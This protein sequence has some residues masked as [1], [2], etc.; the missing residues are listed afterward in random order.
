MTAG[1]KASYDWFKK[2]IKTYIPKSK[3]DEEYVKMQRRKISSGSV[4]TFNYKQPVGKGKKSLRFFDEHPVDII[5]YIK[6]N[7]MMC[8][9]FHYAPRVFRKSVMAYIIKMNK[10]QIK[11]DKRFELTYKEMKMYL[12]RNGL[13]LMIHK[14]KVNRITN[15]KYVP[16]SDWK[17]IFE[18]PTEK[19]VIQDP[20]MSED[21]LYKMI[22]SHSTKTK[23]SKNVRFNR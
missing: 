2:Q 21:D 23:K 7:D 9:N 14:Y 11:N 18:L 3:Q 6:G 5:L 22:R 16:S 12:K 17:Y 4:I 20:D 10:Q 8:L 1:Q 15:L 13:E 19:F